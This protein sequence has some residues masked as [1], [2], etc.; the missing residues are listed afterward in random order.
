MKSVKSVSVEPGP[1][2]LAY[3]GRTLA[4]RLLAEVRTFEARYELSSDQ[5]ES[6]LERGE[7]R[8]TAEVAEWLIAYRTL[9]GLD[10]EREARTQ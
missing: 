8:E 2:E 5:L 6:V 3:A 4:T 10:S 9:R 7:I 1:V